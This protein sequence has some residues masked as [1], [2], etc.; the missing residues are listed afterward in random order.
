MPERAPNAL[1]GVQLFLMT[2]S[3]V[4]GRR[5]GLSPIMASEAEFAVLV[6]RLGYYISAL[7]HL[8]Y[9]GMTVLALETFI[10]MSLTVEHN[11]AGTLLSGKFDRLS[12][13]DSP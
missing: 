1:S 11:L 7:L 8:E 3:T 4:V 5:E 10:S 2:F 6:V 9:S 13:R 12:S